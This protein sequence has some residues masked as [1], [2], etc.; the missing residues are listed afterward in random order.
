MMLDLVYLRKIAAE[1]IRNGEGWYCCSCG[2]DLAEAADEIERL[3][4][5]L[6]E[7][8]KDIEELEAE[9]LK[10]IPEAQAEDVDKPWEPIMEF[11]D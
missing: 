7:A 5:E 10:R 9:L 1:P 11:D 6:A 3:Q 2:E 4:K 8:N